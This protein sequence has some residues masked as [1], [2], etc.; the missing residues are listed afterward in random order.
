MKIIA[1]TYRDNFLCEVSADEIAKIAGYSYTT[2]MPN[3][4]R[5]EVGQTIQV[6]K[7]WDALS[8]VRDRKD[9]VAKCAAQLKTISTRL[10]SVNET[11]AQPIIEVKK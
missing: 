5:L 11:L 7:L 4:S 10:N 1:S 6:S 8:F 3:G 2:S 9:E